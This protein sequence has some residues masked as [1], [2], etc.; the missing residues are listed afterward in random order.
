VVAFARAVLLSFALV[1]LAAA[2]K[3]Y[4]Y[5]GN[6]D[7]HSAL[8]AWGTADG[9]NTIGRSSPS[10]GEAT[11]RIAGR[12]LLSR[13]N[14]LVVAD[15]KPD[16]EYPYEISLGGQIIGRG[17]VRTWPESSNRLVF[18]AIGDW[19]NG[20]P[21]QYAIARAMWNEFERRASSNN[22][23]RF[24][25]SLGDNIYGD[26]ATFLFGYKHTGDEDVDWGT[27]FFE[28]YK[29]L[30]AQIPFYPVLGN[31]D[32]N[33]TESRGDLTA[34][35]DN[36]FFPGDKPARW[37]NF[38]F[39]NLA[40]FFALD[41]TRNT[42]S[43]P[44]R[45]AYLESGAQFQWMRQV[46]PSS[47]LPWK[48]P[49]LHHPPFNAGPR[50]VANHG[51]LEHWMKLFEASGVKVAFS[52]HEHNLQF[53]EANERSGGI[54]YVVSGAGGELRAGDVRRSMRAQNIAGWAPQRHFMVVEIEGKIMR[55]TPVGAEKIN[56]RNPDGGSIP[57]PL[58]VTI[59]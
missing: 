17:N 16:T 58:T 52:G 4:N 9:V 35:L 22:P 56:V 23:V 50:H 20:G 3:Y 31:H 21:G 54:R 39:A 43:G 38:R 18:F 40:E 42:E 29:P 2:P 44:P 13:Q 48:I 59:P 28:P 45:A 46:I 49:Y 19:G 41:T 5:V 15:L 57:M 47:K 32:G 33:E 36:F 55:I 30:L 1:S 51:N 27:K 37:Y 12:T 24:I 8:L 34:Y 25:I 6:V 11:V 26:V 10:R 14:W 7:S 53:S